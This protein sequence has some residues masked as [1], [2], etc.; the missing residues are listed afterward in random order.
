MIS[1]RLLNRFAREISIVHAI[2]LDCRVLVRTAN[3]VRLEQY[4]LIVN[5]TKP[6]KKQLIDFKRRCF[7]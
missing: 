5:V 1:N 2:N 6:S 4:A 7:L 3:K